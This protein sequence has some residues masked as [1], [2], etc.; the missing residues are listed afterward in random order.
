[1]PYRL[2]GASGDVTFELRPGAP[3]V[4]GRALSSDLPVL[5]PTVSRRHAEVTIETA[6]VS[7]RDLGSSNGTF[8]NGNRIT[9]A[10]LAPGDRII[11]G[12]V[13]FELR[14][15]SPVLIDDATA[16]GMRRVARAGT[17]IV[18]Q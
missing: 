17:T 5:D 16:E 7:I 15:L 10:R 14:E 11:F 1:M 8:V 2:V 6:G 13:L 12:K 9:S 18:R 4:L 3:L